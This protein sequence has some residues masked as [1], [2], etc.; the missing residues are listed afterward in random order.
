VLGN[1]IWPLERVGL[2]ASSVEVSESRFSGNYGVEYRSWVTMFV[3]ERL[4]LE[5][6]QFRLRPSFLSAI[7]QIGIS[8]T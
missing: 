6:K 4:N 7:P 8:L 5:G 2:S 1:P 3:P